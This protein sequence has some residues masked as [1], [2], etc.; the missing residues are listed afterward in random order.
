MGDETN[1]IGLAGGT[2]LALALAGLLAA[3]AFAAAR[4]PLAARGIGIQLVGSAASFPLDPLARIY[5]TGEFAPGST[6]ARQIAITNTTRQAQTISL[7]SAAASMHRGAF[8]FAPSRTQNELSGW[9]SVSHPVLRLVAGATAVETVTIRVPA[10]ASAGERYSVVW[11]AVTAPSARAGGVNLVNRVGVRVYLSVGSGGAPP[12][13]FVLGRPRATRSGAGKP[14]VVT[15]V[16]NGGEGTIALRGTLV[17]SGGPGG[18]RAGPFPLRLARPLAPHSSRRITLQLNTRLPRGPWHVQITLTSGS[19][20]R[21]SS[22]TI[23][24]PALRARP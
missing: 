12:V 2:A 13:R 15:S 9:T 3:S 16:R 1:R 8:T 19:A 6:S 11:A 21:S 4:P 22:A 18:L 24:F 10:R 17:L 5:I 20:Q 14:V 7:Y 23:M